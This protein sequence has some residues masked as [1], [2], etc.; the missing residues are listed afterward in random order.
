MRELFIRKRNVLVR[1]VA[2]LTSA[3]GREVHVHDLI[4]IAST[5]TAFGTLGSSTSII[6]FYITCGTSYGN[7]CF[8]MCI[9][10]MP[11]PNSRLLQDTVIGTAMT[12][13]QSPLQ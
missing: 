2:P 3:P 1:G 4:I 7:A 10:V 13:Q 8:S 5:V 9:Q 11:V 12:A 6:A